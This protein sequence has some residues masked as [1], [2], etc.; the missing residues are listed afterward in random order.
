V[1]IYN[2][3]YANIGYRLGSLPSSHRQIEPELMRRLMNDNRIRDISS[4][5]QTKGLNFLDG[6]SIVGS[7]SED[8]EFSSDDMRRFWFNPKNIQ[9][10]TFTGSKAFPREM[11]GPTSENILLSNS[12]LDL[13]V[14]YYNSTYIDYN[15]EAP[16][17]E[18]TDDS[19]IIRVQINKF[20]RCRIGSEVFGSTSSSRYV[21]S[22][23]VL[24]NFVT[25]D[26]KVDCYPGQV[27]YFFKHIVDLEDR[28][29]EHNLAFIRWYKPAE[30]A[31]N[32]YYFSVDDEEST[33]NVELWRDE[34]LPD[35]RDCIVPVQN[36]LSRFV[37]VEYQ[38]STRQNAV[39]YIAVNPINRKFNIR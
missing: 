18:G 12:M 13:M 27:R 14:E 15:F 16:F 33:C 9:E 38:I 32:R 24:V 8:D 28:A 36:I 20:G 29:V 5:V 3:K 6:R 7:I 22:S 11:L 34:F 31:K 23:F 17:R 4:Q 21:N 26:D 10:S 25:S 37:P 30:T 39:K 2:T 19:I 35:G 1:T